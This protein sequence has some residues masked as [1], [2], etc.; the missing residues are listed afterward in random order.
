M[1][2][3]LTPPTVVTSDLHGMPEPSTSLVGPNGQVEVVGVEAGR[4][5]I[6]D[7]AFGARAS[8]R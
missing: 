7:L 4:K 1:L 8:T 3:P 6:R 5:R 2:S